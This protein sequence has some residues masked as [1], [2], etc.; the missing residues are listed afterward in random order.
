MAKK[1]RK[2]LYITLIS[3]AIFAIVLS[4]FLFKNKDESIAIKTEKVELRTITQKVSAIGKIRPETEVKISSEAS[5]E[6]MFLGFRD[7][8]SVNKGQLLVRIQPDIVQSQLE[9]FT[10]SADAAKITIDATKAEMD[11]AQADFKRI[12]DLYAKQ[13]ASREEFDRAK[14]TLEQ[15][16]SRFRSSGSDYTRA[17]SALKQMRSQASRTTL[18]SPMSGTVT[19]LSVEAGEKVVGTAQ[20]QGTEMMRIADLNIMNAWVDVDENDIVFV[21][22]GDT[23]R[24]RV[25]AMPD[26]ELFGYVYEIGHSAKTSAAGT[27][28]EVTNFEVRIRIIDKDKRLR[29]GMSCSVEISTETHPNVLSVPLQSVTVRSMQASEPEISSGSIQQQEEKKKSNSKRPP[30]VVFLKD[31][32]KAKMVKV[33]TGLS[34]HGFIEIKKGLKVGQEIIS[35]SFQA[36]NKLLQ[37]GSIIKIDTVS[38]VSSMKK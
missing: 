31:G 11:R 34:D 23:A 2:A 13:Y 17:F 5:G 4:Y 33:E 32:D 24:I 10:A 3:V 12:S 27:Q 20:M 35:G 36:I 28:E 16:Q 15:A 6:I 26:E 8:D 7:G 37:D 19:S 25:D 38:S 1:S 18:Y 9:Q 30:S 22:I 29:P 14:S 21:K